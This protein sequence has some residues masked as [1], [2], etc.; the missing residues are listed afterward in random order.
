VDLAT[1]E[2]VRDIPLYAS[3]TRSASRGESGEAWDAMSAQE[4][5]RMLE[6]LVRYE[7]AR[8]VPK[9]IAP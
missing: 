4:K 5:V 1:G 8:E 3:T 7:T 2:V 9:L 6:T